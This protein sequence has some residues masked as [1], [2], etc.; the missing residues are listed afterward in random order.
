M[1]ISGFAEYK[2]LEDYKEENLGKYILF[3]ICFY[4]CL[5]RMQNPTQSSNEYITSSLD[6][7]R[8]DIGVASYYNLQK[9]TIDF[10]THTPSN[11]DLVKF[12]VLRISGKR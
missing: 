7:N 11:K 5:R 12:I 9:A 2:T 4:V 3:L 10:S 8:F 1:Y 6:G